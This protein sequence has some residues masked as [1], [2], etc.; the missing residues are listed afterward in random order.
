MKRFTYILFCLFW[1]QTSIAQEENILPDSANQTAQS[2]SLVEILPT[3]AKEAM[4]IRQNLLPDIQ[5]PIISDS[6]IMIDSLASEV[7]RMGVTTD[8]LISD[9]QGHNFN[10][11][12]N[13]KWTDLIQSLET[14]EKNLG[15]YTSDLQEIES[16]LKIQ[17]ENWKIKESGLKELE[18]AENIAVPVGRFITLLDSTLKIVQDSLQTSFQILEKTTVSLIA[19]NTHL[20]EVNGLKEQEIGYI[21]SMKE[22]AIW[23]MSYST[24]TTLMMYDSSLLYQFRI[25]DSNTYIRNSWHILLLLLFLFLLIFCGLLWLK[26]EHLNM[27]VPDSHE[28]IERNFLLSRPIA[29]AF[30]FSVLSILLLFQSGMPLLVNKAFVLL[31]LIPFLIIFSG[32]VMKPLRW[33]LFFFVLLFILSNIIVLDPIDKVTQR[34]SQIFLTITTGIF[35]IWF[36]VRRHSF[37]QD[38]G[39]KQLL[40]RFLNRFSPLYLILLGAALILD[41]LGYINLATALNH[42][43]I[44]SITTASILGTAYMSLKMLV[45][46]FIHTRFGETS[47]LI[48]ERRESLYNG[49][50]KI[51]WI[52]TIF[53][54]IKISL[55]GYHVLDPI[56]AWL[57]KIWGIG[58]QVGTLFVSIGEVITFFLIII[59]SWL[60]SYALKTILQ[61]EVLNRFNLSRGVPNAIS[62]LFYYFLVI[63]SFMLALAYIG[64]N[65]SNLGLLAGAL[66][67][68]IGFGLQ[69]LIGNFIAGLILAFERPVTVGDRISIDNLEGYVIKVGIRV[70]VIRQYDGSQLIIPNAD[71]ITHKVTNWSLSKFKKRYIITIHTQLQSEPETVL[72]A[73][74]NAVKKVSGVLPDPPPDTYFRGVVDRSLEFALYYWVSDNLFE[75]QSN[76]NLAVQKALNEANIKLEIPLPVNLQK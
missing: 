55:R 52:I 34:F 21:F 41:I 10:E 71:L 45:F 76:V 20:N 70:S 1:I 43:T 72:K 16:G 4:R 60:I 9:N 26:K 29:S 13:L 66:G 58:Y 37:H 73:I 51:L 50:V 18:Y 40:Y 15:T 19:A 12:L 7:E 11:S 30:M 36:L 49:F 5:Q 38:T 8:V 68:G 25:E 44:V 39:S 65:L 54:W 31:F 17:M 14:I 27:D 46:L 75:V 61:K 35:F 22:P 28:V 63:S 48:K 74:N 53:L 32:I 67:F 2:V 47:I 64:F 69:N 42:G 3:I 24:D 6:K 57:E 59:F 23:N 33:S 56:T 62:S